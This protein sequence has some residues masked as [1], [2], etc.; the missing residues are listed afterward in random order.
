MTYSVHKSASWASLHPEMPVLH[1]CAPRAAAAAGS[2]WCHLHTVWGGCECHSTPAAHSQPKPPA[3]GSYRHLPWM[4]TEQVHFKK[5]QTC[6]DLL[7]WFSICGN[8][9]I[10]HQT[11]GVVFFC[12]V[13]VKQQNYKK[14]LSYFRKHS[15]VSHQSHK[16]VSEIKTYRWW[17]FKNNF[18]QAAV[19]SL[20][21][22]GI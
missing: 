8:P 17:G 21:E 11:A 1:H 15:Q 19:E 6:S 7:C 20:S 13:F 5:G 9:L 10:I 16:R 14:C 4:K 18:L 2:V 22:W 12:F 3:G